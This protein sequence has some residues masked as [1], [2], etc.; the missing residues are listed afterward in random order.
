MGSTQR[1]TD[2]MMRKHAPGN[3]QRAAF[4]AQANSRRATCSMQPDAQHAMDN[5]QHATRGTTDT[6]ERAAC[7]IDHATDRNPVQRTT[8][9]MH[10]PKCNGQRAPRKACSA[11]RPS[12][13]DERPR[14]CADVTC[15]L[16]QRR[17]AV[18][19]SKRHCACGHG[20]IIAQAHARTHEI[21]APGGI[22]QLN[23]PQSEQ[24]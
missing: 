22:S 7:N 4:S 9:S 8:S 10:Q 1:A 20:A 6:I 19:H 5:T 16:Q 23:T 12:H 11:Q 17:A 14:A 13:T 2:N 21:H 24:A 3:T 15:R 18:R